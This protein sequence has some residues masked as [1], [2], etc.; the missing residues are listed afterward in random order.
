MANLDKWNVLKE[1]LRGM[2]SIL[3][4]YSGGTDSAFLLKTASDV[5]QDRVLA[6]IARS[7]TYPSEEYEQALHLAQALHVRTVTIH[8]EELADP[9]FNANPPER[10]YF[11]KGELFGKLKALAEAN[12]LRYVAD[13]TNMDD[14]SD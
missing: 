4:A 11:C 10:C 1:I 9:R 6:V 7:E 8:T 14:A 3:V 2:E 13:G 5:L 12:G